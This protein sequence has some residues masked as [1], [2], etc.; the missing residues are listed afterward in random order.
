MEQ[1]KGRVQCPKCLDGLTP[2]KSGDRVLICDSIIG[3]AGGKKRHR[4][5][6]FTHTSAS[7]AWDS[8]AGGPRTW[9]PG[10]ECVCGPTSVIHHFDDPVG[11]KPWTGCFLFPGDIKDALASGRLIAT[12]RRA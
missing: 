12:G 11:R 7:E 2:L 8:A 4:E 9:K 5:Y 6:I 10:E 1:D 3:R